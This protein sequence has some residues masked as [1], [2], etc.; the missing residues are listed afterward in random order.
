MFSIV[1]QTGKA[2][3]PT[4]CDILREGTTIEITPPAGQDIYGIVL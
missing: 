3:E 2:I 4:E 1:D